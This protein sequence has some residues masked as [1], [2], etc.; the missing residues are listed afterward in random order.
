MS[1]DVSEKLDQVIELLYKIAGSLETIE[2][3]S[4]VLEDKVSSIALG[5]D[6]HLTDMAV[7]L[8]TITDGVTTIVTHVEPE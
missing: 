6:L 7:A 8:E 5:I 3:H 1:D 2:G 4:D